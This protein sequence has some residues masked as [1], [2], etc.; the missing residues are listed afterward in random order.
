MAMRSAGRLVV[1]LALL[2]QGC[3]GLIPGRAAIPEP[4]V[5]APTPG[6]AP[7]GGTFAIERGR[8]GLVI[9]APH[10]TSDSATDLIGAELARLT[11]W[12]AVVVRG[13]SHLD[14]A[15]RRLNVNRPTESVPGEA[16]RLETRT[17]AAQEVYEAYRAHV[18]AASQGP[19]R[20]YVE[21]HG[22]GR[23]E[24]A[25]RIEI[26]TVGLNRDEAWRLKVLLELVRDVHVRG[27]EGLPRFEVLVEP[28]DRLHYTASATKEQGVL[29]TAERALHIELPR[30]ARITYREAYTALLADFLTQAGRLFVPPGR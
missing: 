23:Q 25:G 21:V 2:L 28:L 12:S 5:K 26:A 13:F 6:P 8:P 16:P 15:G 10:G 17:P 24:S 4:A 22:N 29:K 3:A 27:R 7:S 11:G 18:A 1:S 30:A 14:P 9:A 20:F 19:L